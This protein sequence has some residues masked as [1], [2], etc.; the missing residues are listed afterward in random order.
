M[1]IW[2]NSI[3]FESV[4]KALFTVASQRTSIRM[5]DETI[6]SSIKTLENKYDFLKF[7]N[8]GGTK[9]I[10]KV[11]LLLVFHQK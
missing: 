4:L 1:E 3:L 11:I 10:H 5:A 2:K 8:T 7:V 6:G 9:K